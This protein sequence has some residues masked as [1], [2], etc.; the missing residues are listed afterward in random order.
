[1][2]R[3]SVPRV[4]S[5]RSIADPRALSRW[6]RTLVL[7]SSTA[8]NRGSALTGQQTDPQN[9][10]VSKCNSARYA[11]VTAAAMSLLRAPPPKWGDSAD[12]ESAVAHHSCRLRLVRD[13]SLS[14]P[15]ERDLCV[16]AKNGD[17]DALGEIL[18]GY[19][20]RLYRSVLLARLGRKA[21]AEEALSIT[22]AR[23]VERFGQFEWQDVGVYPWLRVIALHVAIDQLRREKRE[24]LFVPEDLER[25]LEAARRESDKS[26]DELERQDLEYARQRV[27]SLLDRLNPR[28]ARA[29]RLRVLDG[30][31]REY[32]ANALSVTVGTFDVLLHRALS[33]L[34]QELGRKQGA[35]A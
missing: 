26:V 5:R 13:V 23:V 14:L 7:N 34:R 35:P 6:E 12:I 8:Q 11:H 9:A 29:I 20:P 21:D 15:K 22:Y 27:T 2:A 3:R 28:Y 31:D 1:L 30:Q 4:G 17:R 16:R 18:R 10:C 33:A 24:R 25:T 19:G 32:C